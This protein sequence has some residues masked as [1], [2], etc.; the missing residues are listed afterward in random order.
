[1]GASIFA[2]LFH[3]MMARTKV[4]QT[5]VIDRKQM[6]S[7]GAA[8][9][10]T[11]AYIFTIDSSGRQLRGQRL[12]H[13]VGMGGPAS[14]GIWMSTVLVVNGDFDRRLCAQT[15]I[16]RCSICI[17]MMVHARACI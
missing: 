9:A 13:R 2:H 1:M 7:S 8:T 10:T 16:F 4:Q 14:S 17:P 3:R 6:R 5:K 12:E 15:G 11:D